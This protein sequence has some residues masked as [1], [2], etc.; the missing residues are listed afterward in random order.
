MTTNVIELD[1]IQKRFGKFEA[2]KDVSFTLASGQ[3]LG[4]LGPN[5]A[6][7]STTIRKPYLAR[8]LGMMMLRFIRELLTSRAMFI[9]GRI[10]PAAKSLT[11]Y[12]A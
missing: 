2:L 6:G 5:G 7:K 12:S 11:C 8:T 9:C 1:H 10:C 4:F 3:V